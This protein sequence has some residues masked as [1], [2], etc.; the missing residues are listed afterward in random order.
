MPSAK[1]QRTVFCLS[2]ILVVIFLVSV[3]TLAA[4]QY[5]RVD[6]VSDLSGA[7]HHTDPNLKNGW[8]LAFFPNGPFWV[9]DNTTGLSTL[10]D[11]F[12]NV[13]PLV[14]SI[15]LAAN[16][17]FGPIA[18]PTGM[19]ANQTAG[20]VISAHNQSGPALFIFDTEDGT[21]SGWNPNVDATH[22]IVAVDN[23]ASFAVY[24]GLT[25]ATIDDA[26]LIYAADFNNNKVDVFDSSFNPVILGPGAFV[27]P[28]LP[29]GMAVYGIQE[30]R[31]KLFVAYASTSITP[32]QGGVVDVFSADGRFI[33]RVSANGPG[34]PLEAPWGM[35][36]APD[37][38]G[39][40][41]RKL[42]VGNVDDGH[43][44][45]FNPK[46]GAF[47]GQLKDTKGNTI[48]IDEL[49]ALA[50]GAGNPANGK[51]NELFFTAGPN[52]YADGLFGVISVPEDD[53]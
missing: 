8:G 46:N 27:D 12:G 9:S 5:R 39:P 7:A 53:E 36:L 28:N 37:D 31:G 21:I 50:F 49:W 6:L 45:I 11:H 26:T 19:V 25:M 2:L 23:S 15:P 44:S 29:T 32:F 24:L 43:I 30:I 42:L 47:L 18:S 41:S 52:F 35:V 34:G 51:R 40:A 38:F 22:A 17:F 14:V 20:F 16:P 13:L 3:S 4:A 1:K 33:R 10:Y 48:A